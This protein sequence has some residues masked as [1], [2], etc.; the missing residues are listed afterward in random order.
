MPRASALLL[1]LAL[2]GC[3]T[4]TVR[5][6]NWRGK[7]VRCWLTLEHV[8]DHGPVTVGNVDCDAYALGAGEDRLTLLVPT[9]EH[10]ERWGGQRPGDSGAPVL[11]DE[12]R[13]GL[14]QGA[15]IRRLPE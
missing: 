11:D 1:C 9:A 8:T 15:R 3:N 4:A 7:A 13:L 10:F 2:A 12:G 6:G 5:A 14:W